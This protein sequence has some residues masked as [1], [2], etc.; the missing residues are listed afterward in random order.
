MHSLPY[1]IPEQL[2]L[3]RL[4]SISQSTEREPGPDVS[5]L[6]TNIFT[7]AVFMRRTTAKHLARLWS[8]ATKSEGVCDAVVA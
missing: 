7:L 8:P 5:P 6:R 4:G 1:F 2:K 3:L